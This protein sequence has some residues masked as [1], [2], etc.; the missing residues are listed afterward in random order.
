MDGVINLLCIRCQRFSPEHIIVFQRIFIGQSGC[1]IINDS[2][3]EMQVLLQRTA[4]QYHLQIGK[5]MCSIVFRKEKRNACLLSFF[6]T[7]SRSIFPKFTEINKMLFS[8]RFNILFAASRQTTPGQHSYH[9]KQFF[10]ILM[11]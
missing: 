9:K 10:H 1:H 6:R 7:R 2:Q 5:Y 11:D 3:L 8:E 4:C